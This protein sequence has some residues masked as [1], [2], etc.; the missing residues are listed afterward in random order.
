MTKKI[1]LYRCKTGSGVQWLVRWYGSYDPGTGKQRRYGRRFTLKKNAEKFQKQKEKELGQ[2][3]P[4]DPSNETLKEYTVRWLHNKTKID[5]LRPATVLLYRQTLDRLYN[6]F[7]TERLLRTIDRKTAKAFLANLKT[8]V[9]GKDNLSNWSKHRVLRHCKTLFSE[10]AEDGVITNNPFKGLKGWKCIP[11]DWYYLKADEYFALLDVTPSLR[12]KVLYALAYT[13][14]LRKS[15]ALALYWTNIDFDKGRVHITNRP[16]TTEYPP[17]DI[18]DTDVRVI[19]LPKLTLDLLTQLH[20]ES[21]DKEPFVLMDK[22]GC[23]RIR[24]KWQQCQKQDRPWLNRYWANNVTRDFHLRV[25]RA[26]IEPNNK[27]LTVHV[28]RK[29]C[30]QNWANTLPMNVVQEFMGHGS[31][32]TTAKFYSIVDDDHFDKATET[33]NDLLK[34]E[35]EKAGEEKTDTKLTFSDNLEPNQDVRQ[36]E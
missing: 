9:S 36:P 17:F 10:A 25:L 1:G 3:T 14:G 4:R 33:M 32:D 16:A 23:Q 13:A 8:I 29:C 20:L 35:P 21:P 11:S 2:G 6:Y 27:E 18:K 26:E 34:T 15:E 24:T 28:L 19:P 12:E 31:I 5:G 22:Q 7:G 30:G